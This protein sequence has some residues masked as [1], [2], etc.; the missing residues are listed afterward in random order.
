MASPTGQPRQN[1]T[2]RSSS[3]GQ[4]GLGPAGRPIVSA[5]HPVDQ[6]TAPPGRGVLARGGSPPLRMGTL[7]ALVSQGLMFGLGM[8]DV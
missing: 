3:L 2:M 7:T 8:P 6:A 4:D 5:E 1:E